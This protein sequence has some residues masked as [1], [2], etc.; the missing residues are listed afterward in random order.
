MADE[1]WYK[2]PETWEMRTDIDSALQDIVEYVEGC[3]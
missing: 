2:L 3:S 1:Q